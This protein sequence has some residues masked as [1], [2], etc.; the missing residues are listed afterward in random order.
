MNILIDISH[1]GQVHLFKNIYFKLKAKHNI[2]W[3]TRD[4]PIAKKLLEQYQIPYINLGK[5]S[6][7]IFG[8][9]ID[10]ILQDIKLFFIVKTIGDNWNLQFLHQS[11]TD[12]RLL[13][14]LPLPNIDICY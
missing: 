12:E 7:S 1:P 5:K 3:T 14:Y 9:A 8:K 4:I 13:L 6:N 11:G 10:I 2:I